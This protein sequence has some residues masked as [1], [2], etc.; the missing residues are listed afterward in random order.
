MGKP[1]VFSTAAI[2]AMQD[3]ELT[4]QKWR[5]YLWVSLHDGMSLLSGKGSGCYA[6]NKTLF[7]EAGCDYSS[8]CRALSKLVKRGHLI[9]EQVGRSTRYRVT[10]PEPNSLQA[11]NIS[12]SAIGGEPASENAPIT[13][14]PKWQALEKA[15]EREGDYS[16]LSGEL[17][18]VETEGLNSIKMA[19]FSD[20]GLNGAEAPALRGVS[21]SAWLAQNS[22]RFTNLDTPAQLCR[23][24]EAFKA[25]G[26][27]A[28]RIESRDRSAW[29]EWLFTIADEFAGQPVGHHA[30]RLYEELI[31]F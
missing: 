2:S 11:C 29:V 19:G 3:T 18:S 27:D 4:G 26:G 14:K 23:F 8:G 21:I 9:R 13:C 31:P 30:Q 1:R 7:D 5:I 16:P 10:F 25:V 28:E 17:H 15:G 12:A 6:S 24:E 22:K 20:F